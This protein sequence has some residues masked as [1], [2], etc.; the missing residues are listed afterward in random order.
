MDGNILERNLKTAGRD[1]KWL[2]NCLKSKGSK[3]N[4]IFLA[5]LDSNGTL[6]IFRSSDREIKNDF[7]E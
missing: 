1:I 7:F 3:I 6:N 2:E 4:D 5:T